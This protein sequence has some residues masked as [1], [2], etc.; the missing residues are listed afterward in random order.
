MHPKTAPMM[1]I[2]FNRRV[3]RQKAVNDIDVIQ[4][5]YP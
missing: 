4:R 1:V 3:A 5:S 2:E